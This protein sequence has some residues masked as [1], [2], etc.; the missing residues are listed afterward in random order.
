MALSIQNTNGQSIGNKAASAV[1]RT[2]AITAK[3]GGK[4]S[5]PYPKPPMGGIF[6]KKSKTGIGYTDRNIPNKLA[7]I[8]GS[9]K[10]GASSLKSAVVGK[11]KK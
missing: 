6:M 2:K 4:S 5:N 7:D 9:I 1:S 3:I 8:G 10:K 11:L